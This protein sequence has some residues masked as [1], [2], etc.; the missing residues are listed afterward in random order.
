[1][2]SVEKVFCS[3]DVGAVSLSLN[4]LLKLKSKDTLVC[5]DMRLP[6]EGV[7]RVNGSVWAYVTIDHHIEGGMSV[8]IKKLAANGET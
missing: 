5:R 3:L 7:L 4:D 8:E 2:N 1:M 6:F